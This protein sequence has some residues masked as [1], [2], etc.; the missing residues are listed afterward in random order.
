MTIDSHQ[1]FWMMARGDYHWMRPDI[2]I[3]CRDYLPED[4]LPVLS[5]H[6]ID[7][8]VLVQA[9]Q[10]TA[11]T[12]FLLALARDHDFIAGVVGW[13][14][15]DSAEFP[16]QFERYRANPKFIGLRPMLQDLADDA[17]ILRPKV[18]QSL[19]L[20][21]SADFPF[22]FLTYTR[23]L[24]YVL[25]ALRSAPG[26]R[27]VI[28][29]ASKPAIRAC[30]TEPWKTLIAEA[31][32]R[33]NLHCKLSGMITEADH[34]NW[35]VDDLRPYVD[36]VVD[37]FGWERVMFGS[38]WPVCRVAGEYGQVIDSLRQILGTHWDK[39]AEEALFGG[40]AERFYKLESAPA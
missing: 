33:E 3:L 13:L 36:H 11:E 24:P 27:A 4:L 25:L 10:T 34:Q 19:R 39:P 32:K 8:T 35:K 22:E 30:Q 26:L 20:V 29:H 17:W 28:D 16:E 38:D 23:H 31:A 12:D 7:K 6:G 18:I 21:A 14:D 5:S 1:H 9:A 40:N 37:S 15:M 2:P